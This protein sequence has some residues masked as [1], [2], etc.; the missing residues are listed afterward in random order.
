[1]I[2]ELVIYVRLARAIQCALIYDSA[3]IELLDTLIPEL[4]DDPKFDERKFV[5]ACGIDPHAYFSRFWR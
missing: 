5:E 2:E 1:M 3:R 4:S